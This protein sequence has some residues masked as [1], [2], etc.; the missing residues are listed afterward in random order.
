M[1]ATGF[2]RAVLARG[3][4]RVDRRKRKMLVVD[5]S[6]SVIASPLC[7]VLRGGV[8]A[9]WSVL[10]D[11]RAGCEASQGAH[12]AGCGVCVP[13]VV[14][15][16]QCVDRVLRGHKPLSVRCHRR[17][18]YVRCKPC[19]VFAQSRGFRG[20]N[21]VC[22]CCDAGGCARVRAQGKHVECCGVVDDMDGVCCTRHR[23]CRRCRVGEAASVRR[24][25]GGCVGCM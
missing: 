4:H 25:H 22:S 19:R 8:W 13:Q 1:R 11:T 9:L 18:G 12:G 16:C 23:A 7:V 20:T 24:F 10:E 15:Q 21:R 3:M 5:D 6:D 14:L 17:D 2:A